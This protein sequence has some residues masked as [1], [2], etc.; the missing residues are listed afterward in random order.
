MKFSTSDTAAML[1]AMGGPVTIGGVDYTGDFADPGKPV[2][3]N[4]ETIITDSPTLLLSEAV[5]ALVTKD[6]TVLTIGGVNYQAYGKT[7]D[8][9]G[10]VDLDLTRDF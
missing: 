7:P 5:A 9:V 3:R 6:S 2:F 4:G 1:S 10:F 8:G